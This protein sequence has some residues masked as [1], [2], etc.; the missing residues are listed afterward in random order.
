MKTK[1]DETT[2]TLW[3][4]GE[5]E[6]DELTRIEAWA[7]DHP[8]ILA[9]R[10]AVQAMSANIR[11]NIPAS[12]EP[13]YPKFFNQHILRHIDD[14]VIPAAIEQQKGSFFQQFGRWLA[15]PVAAGA[16][17]VC[18]YLGTQ[19]GEG[20]DPTTPVYTVSA[21]PTVYTP[22]GGVSGAMFDSEDAGAT[23]IVLE[24]LEDIP[25]DLEMVGEPS[26]Q[27][28]GSGA[29]MVNTELVF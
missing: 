4:D 16:M 15:I 13:P 11:G 24:G 29:V 22:D 23:V 25:D 12:I 19:A 3:M 1:P 9:E 8:E 10:D 2:L 17:A 26:S 18:F 7:Q 21:T 5:L 27:R 20:P 14:E 28:P 6:G